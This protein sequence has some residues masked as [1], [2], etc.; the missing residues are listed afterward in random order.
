MPTMSDGAIGPDGKL[1]D[2]DSQHKGLFTLSPVRGSPKSLEEPDQSELYHPY[3]K[4]IVG[5]PQV[6]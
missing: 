1:L 6:D 2:L 3:P 4:G 5:R